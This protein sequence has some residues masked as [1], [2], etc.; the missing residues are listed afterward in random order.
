MANSGAS[1]PVVNAAANAAAAAALNG[2]TPAAAANAA[3]VAATPLLSNTNKALAKASEEVQGAST[4]RGSYSAPIVPGAGN[5][6]NRA[7]QQLSQTNA[8]R[9]AQARANNAERRA[10]NELAAKGTP[11][12]APGA[13]LFAG[14]TVAKG[15]RKRRAHTRSRRNRRNTKKNRK[16]RA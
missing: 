9:N 14:L 15:G 5:N 13:N 1:L 2:A 10:R 16:N 11:T 7:T 3:A 4:E 6:S 8:A 12:S